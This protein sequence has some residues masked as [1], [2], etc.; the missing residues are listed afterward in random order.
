[1]DHALEG[2]IGDLGEEAAPAPASALASAG[3]S[4]P[5][6]TTPHVFCTADSTLAGLGVW[7]PGRLVT[8][9]VQSAPYAGGTIDTWLWR[10]WTLVRS[11]GAV[12]WK[13]YAG[14][15]PGAPPRRRSTCQ[16]ECPPSLRHAA[17]PKSLIAF[18]PAEEL[19]E[20]VGGPRATGCS[21]LLLPSTPLPPLL[22][23]PRLLPLAIL[24]PAAPWGPL[25]PPILAL[26]ASAA[27]VPIRRCRPLAL[28]RRLS[29]RAL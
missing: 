13:M 28:L 1:M 17:A 7:M 8:R 12:V 18:V 29:F 3:T 20:L 15:L 14:T 26:P 23:W 24:A 22:L 27:C 9:C 6:A 25:A 21:W 5:L 11:D 10:S 16:S 4:T 2:Y 19:K